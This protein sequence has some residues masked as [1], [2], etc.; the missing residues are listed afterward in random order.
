[1]QPS[2]TST[3]AAGCRCWW[4]ALGC[5]WP[6]CWRVW[7]FLRSHPTRPCERSWKATR[8][9]LGAPALHARLAALDPVAASRIDARNV[10]RVIRALEVCLVTGQPI[11]ELQAATPP[12]YHIVRVGLTRPRP[13]LYARIDQRVDEMMAQ[14]LLAETQ[15]LL[16]AGLSP[17]L[18]AL[19]GLGYRQMIQHLQGE[20]SYEAAVAAIK[21]QTRRFVRQQYTWFRLNDPRIAW[22]DLE[23]VR[24]ERV[25]STYSSLKFLSSP[26]SCAKLA[27]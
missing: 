12:P 8:Q 7:A 18:P 24:G 27:A 23:E 3:A 17:Q 26:S 9:Q 2:T 22:L 4:A 14:G 6:R 16:E 25:V 20:L 15:R 10:R 1:M 21:Q 19:T 11:S 13:A 5:T